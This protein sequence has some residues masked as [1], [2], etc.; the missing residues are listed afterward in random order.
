MFRRW[1]NPAVFI[2]LILQFI[3]WPIAWISFNTCFALRIQGKENFP[4]FS[5]PVLFASSHTHH[6]DP[7]LIRNALPWLAYYSPMFYVARKRELYQ[8]HGWRAVLYSDAFFRAWGAY[9]AYAGNN[10]YEQSLKHFL[11]LLQSGRTVTIFPK[12]MQRHDKPPVSHVR[13]G[14]GYLALTTGTPVVPV[15]IQGLTDHAQTRFFARK[16]VTVTFG[17]PLHPYYSTDDIHEPTVEE[18]RTFA[19]TV[20]DAIEQLA[21]ISSCDART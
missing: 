12:G 1:Y 16:R 10:D 6:L 4:K 9:P 20:W 19:G 3:A 21:Y 5:S 14:I 8:W 7:I 18:C 15:S 2:P 17:E 11:A 13:G